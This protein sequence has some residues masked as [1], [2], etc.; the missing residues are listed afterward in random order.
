MKYVLSVG[1]S[2]ATL[3]S[4]CVGISAAEGTSPGT[5]QGPTAAA[6]AEKP[7]ELTQEEKAGRIVMPQQ[8]VRCTLAQKDKSEPYVV[9]VTM[10]PKVKFK[11]GKASEATINWGP[12]SA[13]LLI[14]PLI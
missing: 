4:L 6:P 14:Y 3:P 2:V 12:A 1:A 8:K 9:E 5:A 10:S 13:P 11:D 7:P